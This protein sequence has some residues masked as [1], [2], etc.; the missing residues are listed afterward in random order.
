M[1]STMHE[2]TPSIPQLGLLI[3]VVFCLGIGGYSLLRY[4]SILTPLSMG[5]IYLALFMATLAGYV[6]IALR[7]LHPSTP[8]AI[9]AMRQ[10]SRWG[11]VICGLWLIEVIAGNLASPSQVW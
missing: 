8:E 7:W 11:L 5:V 3:G 6:I 4:P 10:G 1:A 2:R 9:Y